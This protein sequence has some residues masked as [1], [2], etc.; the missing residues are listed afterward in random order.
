MS[1]T[2]AFLKKRLLIALSGVTSIIAFGYISLA[3]LTKTKFNLTASV[4]GFV[5]AV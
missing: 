3:Y 4:G 2:Q 5:L 1:I